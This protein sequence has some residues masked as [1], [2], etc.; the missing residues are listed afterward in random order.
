MPEVTIDFTPVWV[1]Q[2]GRRTPLSQ[3]A[4]PH[5]KNALARLRREGY[6]GLR[7]VEFYLT[8]TPP[9]ADMAEMSFMQEF[10]RVTESP[11]FIWVDFFEEELRSRGV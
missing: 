4:T 6:V 1:S 5:I 11:I 9:T 10:D 7:D 2:N 8:C 3:M